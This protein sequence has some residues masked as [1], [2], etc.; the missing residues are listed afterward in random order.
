MRKCLGIHGLTD[1]FISLLTTWTC[2]DIKRR[3]FNALTILLT[4]LLP[5]SKYGSM[6]IGAMNWYGSTRQVMPWHMATSQ[7]NP[8]HVADLDLQGIE[9]QM[10]C[11]G[12]HLV[13]KDTM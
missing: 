5:F 11:S 9:Y 7:A 2:V 12:L 8:L 13:E 6:S 3:H 1:F 4:I 10:I